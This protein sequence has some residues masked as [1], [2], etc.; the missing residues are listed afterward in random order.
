[1]KNLTANYTLLA[2]DNGTTLVCDGTFNIIIPATQTF[3]EMKVSIKNNGSGTITLTQYA[4]KSIVAGAGCDLVL[5]GTKW[6]VIDT[7]ENITGL[8]LS[9][10]EGGTGRSTTLITAQNDFLVGNAGGTDVEKKTLA[11]TKTILGLDNIILPEK[12]P[13]NAVAATKELTVGGVPADNDTVSIGGVT[14]KWANAIAVLGAK[15]SSELTFSGVAVNADTVTI[16]GKT[17]T[18][19]TAL[20]GAFATGTLTLTGVVIEGETFT[21]GTEVYEIDADGVVTLGNIAVDV[22]AFMTRSQGTLTLGGAIPSAND[23][24]QIGAKTYKYVVTPA[25]ANDIKIGISIDDC[26]DNLVAAIN[27]EAGEGTLYGTGT[28]AN[29]DVTAVKTSGTAMVITAITYGVIGDSIDTIEGFTDAGNDFDAVTLGTTTAGADCT[30]ANADG[31]IISEFNANTALLITATQGGGTT[32]VFTKDV[33]G[34]DT[35]ATTSVLAN[36]GFGAATLGSG[37][38]TIANEVL[39]EATA[40]AAIDNLVLAATAGLQQGVKYSTGTVAL[41]N[42][43]GTKSAVDKFKAEA[44]LYGDAGNAI[45]IAQVMTNATWTGGTLFLTG[46]EEAEAANDVLIGASA[47][48]SID[49][50][51]LA[52]TAGAGA[53]TNYGLGT[54]T[55]PLAT[56]VKKDPATMTC[57]NKIKGL[58]GNSTAIAETGT[59]TS[60]AGAA[61]FLSGGVDGTVGIAN[62]TCADASYIYHAVA[63]QTTADTNWRR[64]T[65]GTAY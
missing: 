3:S 13:V 16:D 53:G 23:T 42:V 6:V 60:W 21:V 19:K 56:A 44:K 25:A 18:F 26:I 31:V 50:L 22:S 17:Y 4:S 24:A 36:G 15:A 51:V 61:V 1:M 2:A 27:H 14:Y 45:A 59:Q 10:A 48:L 47:E 40:E 30:A 49:N 8:P 28:T 34:V 62:E 35:T 54:V 58:I 57:T 55:N 39:V 64:V 29:A 41:A 9:V 63:T 46:G 12:T 11:Q 7:D 20:T 32:V 52:I 33:L 43:N 65:L 37:V 38:D 5:D